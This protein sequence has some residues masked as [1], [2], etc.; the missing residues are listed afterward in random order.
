[1]RGFRRIL[2]ATDFGK[3]STLATADALRLAQAFGSAIDLCHAVRANREPAARSPLCE[4]A[5]LRLEKCREELSAAGVHVDE[6]R[7]PK[8]SA[9]ET[10]LHVA[11]ELES[12]L[13]LIGSGDRST[14]W[15]S[16]PTAE[17]V[18][19]FSWRPVWVSRPRSEGRGQVLV[20]VDFS[21]AS[22]KALHL[23]SALAAK[24]GAPFEVVH[25]VEASELAE[26]ELRA[27]AELVA[28]VATCD[29]R[30]TSEPRCARG[31][32]SDVLAREGRGAQLLVLGR[33][34][35]GGLRRSF[36]GGTAERLLR[37]A[38]CSLLLTSPTR[39]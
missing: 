31:R 14:D 7:V 2:L 33:T 22:K 10:I 25:V 4:Q 20:G 35:L 19:R 34:G 8:G 26:D 5:R 30:P 32:A 27:R 1:V 16:G 24:L 18:A 38:P 39:D 15:A 28:F 21:E 36:V 13:V 37:R 29:V 12:D 9:A 17:T 3:S 6:L 11:D 23:G